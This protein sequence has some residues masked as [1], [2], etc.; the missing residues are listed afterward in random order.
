MK[1]SVRIIVKVI[2][3][4]IKIISENNSLPEFELI[5]NPSIENQIITFLKENYNLLETLCDPKLINAILVNESLLFY[6]SLFYPKDFIDEKNTDKIIDIH[7]KFVY[8]DAI[9]IR[10]AIQIPPY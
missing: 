5:E 6:Y 9:E 10:K 2:D 4:G 3:G 8:E 7:N 1:I